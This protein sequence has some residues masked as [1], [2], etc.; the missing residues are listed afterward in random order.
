MAYHSQN[1]NEY[2]IVSL[3]FQMFFFSFFR[4]LIVS[5]IPEYMLSYSYFYFYIRL[6][7]N[8]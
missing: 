6:L 8:I 3:S 5:F 4:V 1:Q 7:D 2:F